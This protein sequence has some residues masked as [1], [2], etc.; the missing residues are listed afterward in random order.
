MGSGNESEIFTVMLDKIYQSCQRHS[1]LLQAKVLSAPP[2]QPMDSDPE[3]DPEEHE[4]DQ[5]KKAP[6]TGGA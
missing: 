5:T 4:T 1:W 2:M 3:P 6:L